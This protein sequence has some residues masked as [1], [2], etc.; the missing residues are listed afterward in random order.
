MVDFSFDEKMDEAMR[1][2]EA[3]IR[4]EIENFSTNRHLKVEIS[5]A[6]EDEE[7]FE[8]EGYY[9]TIANTTPHMAIGNS[10]LKPHVHR[11]KHHRLDYHIIGIQCRS[12]T[13]VFALQ[14]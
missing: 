6:W 4:K 13:H 10:D 5:I 11:R 3:N 1:E 2:I 8:H 12:L 14:H 7:E 9:R